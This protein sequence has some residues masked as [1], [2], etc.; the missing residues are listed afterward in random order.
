VNGATLTAGTKGIANT[1]YSFNGSTD[2]I[3]M[4]SE[5]TSIKSYSFWMKANSLVTYAGVIG[6]LW[7]DTDKG[8]AVYQVATGEIIAECHD[9]ASY[10]RVIT[11]AGLNQINQWNHVVVVA[12]Y[13]NNLKLYINNI[14]TGTYPALASYVS[15]GR[16]FTIAPQIQTGMT[17]LNGV[18][19]EVRVYNKV[20]STDEITA[21]Y[22]QDK[23]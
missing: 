3:N 15:S 18:V 16:N 10:P 8:C 12:D 4:S 22:N 1:A 21:L 13:R 20:L 5:L 14:L 17:R 11:A 2:Y 19:D 9:P 23:P 7:R 6:T